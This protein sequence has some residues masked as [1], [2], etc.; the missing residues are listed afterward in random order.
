MAV[1]EAERRFY[2]CASGDSLNTPSGL[3]M[4]MSC[5]YS[6]SHTIPCRHN[7][8]DPRFNM[9]SVVYHL[10]DSASVAADVDVCQLELP[11]FLLAAQT[12]I[13][14]VNVSNLH[15]H[16]TQTLS[17]PRGCCMLWLVRTADME[18]TIWLWQS[19]Q[20]YRL[21]SA[22]LGRTRRSIRLAQVPKKRTTKLVAQALTRRPGS[23][24]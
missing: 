3:P 12:L 16:P 15:E 10:S 6:R 17:K 5:M 20:Q 24:L 21:W 8:N 22:M 14:R 18:C 1:A 11:L 9:A 4:P 2:A 19:I 23:C 13:Q 7:T